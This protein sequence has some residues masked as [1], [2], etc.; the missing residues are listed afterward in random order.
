[1]NAPDDLNP[2]Y[3][4]NPYWVRYKNYQT[5]GRNRFIGYAKLDWTV[6]DWMTLTARAAVD[7]YSYIQEERRAVGSIAENFGVGSGD[8][9]S[10]Y[11]VKNGSFNEVNFDLMANFKKNLSD[12]ISLAGLIGT[13]I[14]KRSFSSMYAST[15]GGLA[16]PEIY[17]LANTVSPLLLPEEVDGIIQ[18]N[19]YFGSASLG[20]A[21]MVFIDGTLRIDQSSTLPA[22]NNTYL[23]PSISTSFIFSELIKNDILSLGK[24]RVNYAEVGNDA[25]YSSLND[26]YYQAF[27]F[28][29]NG[30]A[31][32]GRTKLNPEL[33]SERTKSFETGLTLNFMQNRLG[34]DVAYYDNRSVDQIV[35]ASISTAT[36]YNSK[37][38]NAG[39]IS[40]KGVE[41]ML[42]F[43]VL[44][45]AD[46][47]WDINLNWAKN[48][49]EVLK[50]AEGLENLQIAS[51]QGGVTINARVGEPY[52]SIQGT[53]YV[54]Y[55]DIRTPEN[56]II[57]DGIYWKTQTSDQVIGDI[58]PDWTAGIGSSLT[59][60]N[61]KFNFL[62]D[63]KQGGD[64]FSLDM[65]YGT[66][67]GLYEESVGLNELGNP[68]HNY[69]ADGGGLIL[70]GVLPDGTPNTVRS[71]NMGTY[72]TPIGSYTAPNAM[73]VYDAS[74]VKLRE[75]ALTYNIP[76]K[77]FGKFIQSASISFVGSNL[78]IIHK[79]LPHADPET[80]Q[81][82]GNVQGWQSGVMPS[83]RNFGFSL[84]V[85][86]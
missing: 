25:P 35:P 56:R 73:H 75:V 65:W 14:R 60:K 86:F 66:S 82:A 83:A 48:R 39:E 85:N 36:G 32:A 5:D 57:E 76:S 15:N 79:N 31:A 10:G 18:V 54:Y 19:G 6:T 44:K 16:V 33:K 28:S 80:T 43:T 17:S 84:N 12:R 59:Y 63:W 71:D 81:G 70:Q 37:F 42:N 20:I 40:N 55:N 4:D 23:Y 45:T 41:V 24:L 9:S 47:T 50:L 74:Y 26:V 77:I 78:W 53:D 21:N 58:N 27:P 38:V 61:F 62:I 11:A 67:T 8:A 1:M 68:I 29:G 2:A 52:G 22:D 51:L 46:L 13:N 64:I 69:A 7:N 34:L 49:S 30:V 3:W 72:S